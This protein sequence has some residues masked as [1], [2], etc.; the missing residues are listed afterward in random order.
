MKSFIKTIVLLN[1]QK[2]IASKLFIPKKQP[3][4]IEGLIKSKQCSFHTSSRHQALP[5]LI[6][7]LFAKPI[8]KLA[9]ILTGRYSKTTVTHL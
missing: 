8:A 5:P 7:A 4:S 6:W 1:S 3:I 2:Q 9:A